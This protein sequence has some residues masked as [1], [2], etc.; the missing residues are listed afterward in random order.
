MAKA[1][2]FDVGG[3]LLVPDFEMVAAALTDVGLELDRARRDEAHYRAMFEVDEP[4]RR[5]F[6]A[7]Y[8]IGYLGTFEIP[9]A[10][11][12]DAADALASLL[13]APAIDFWSAP[14]KG[15]RETLSALSADGVPIAIVSNSDGTVESSL[16][17]KELCQ[18]GV[19]RFTAVAAIVDSAL[20]GR[21]KPDGRIFEPAISALG[22]EPSETIYVGDSERIDV[23]AALDAGIA[24]VH[25]DPYRLCRHPTGH[26][27]VVALDEVRSLISGCVSSADA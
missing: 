3:V 9:A 11:Y 4:G 25:F 8:S 10:R 24:P 23:A 7:A 21:S 12:D 20:V 18:V 17:R 5:D 15:A 13:K 27:H 2:V 16:L 1:V 22:V 19:G 14:V 6:L 26:D